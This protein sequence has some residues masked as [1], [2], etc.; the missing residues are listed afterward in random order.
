M[1]D[2]DADIE[3]VE[4]GLRRAV[5]LDPGAEVPLVRIMPPIGFE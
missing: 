2:V 1:L 3:T 5:E 4:N